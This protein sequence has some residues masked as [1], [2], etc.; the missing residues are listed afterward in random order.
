V[1]GVQ[2]FLADAA[3]PVSSAWQNLCSLP[4]V[5]YVSHFC[6][7]TGVT[8]KFYV[9]IGMF[10]SKSMCVFW[11]VPWLMHVVAEVLPDA[12]YC[13]RGADGHMELSATD[14]ANCSRD[15][16]FV[17]RPSIFEGSGFTQITRGD[18]VMRMTVHT[19][20]EMR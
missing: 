15:A 20:Y 2:A 14:A 19:E 11:R 5:S 13:R 8:R 6:P 16:R 1:V 10:C 9:T 3:A 18:L 17:T 4:A 12:A 7:E